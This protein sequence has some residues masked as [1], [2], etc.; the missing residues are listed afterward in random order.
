MAWRT[1]GN[2]PIGP[3]SE[4]SLTNPSANDLVAD[5]G[6]VPFSGIYEARIGVGA[7][8]ACK[9]LVQRRNTANDDN[10]GDVLTLRANTSSAQ[11]VYTYTLAAS[12]RLRVLVGENFTGTAEAIIEIE[13][14]S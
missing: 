2:P 10:V 9:F 11:F 3:E 1:T 7:S 4:G 12:Q 8:G 14:L 13:Q 6:A 5:T